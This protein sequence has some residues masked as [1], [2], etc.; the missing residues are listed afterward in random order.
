MN[1]CAKYK[2]RKPKLT[3]LLYSLSNVQ[4]LIFFSQSSY[5]FI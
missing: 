3:L 2:K 1:I 5:S 4:K